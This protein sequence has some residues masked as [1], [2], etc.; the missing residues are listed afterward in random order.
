MQA[1]QC[2]SADAVLQ[3]GSCSALCHVGPQNTSAH[4]CVQ[5]RCL[6]RSLLQLDGLQALVDD[7]KEDEEMRRMAREERG[8][9]LEQVCGRGSSQGVWGG[10]WFCKGVGRPHAC[11]ASGM[12]RQCALP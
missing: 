3:Q 12:W 6:P 10:G 11:G 5:A 2:W 9:L 7:G 4:T 8:A 1:W